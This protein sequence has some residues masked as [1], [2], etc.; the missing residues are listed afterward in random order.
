MK[1]I[2]TD[3][4]SPSRGAD[5]APNDDAPLALLQH[6][7]DTQSILTAVGQLLAARGLKAPWGLPELTP[8]RDFIRTHL[9]RKAKKVAPATL[10]KLTHS[11]KHFQRHCP[12]VNIQ[13]VQGAHVQAWTD[14]LEAEQ[15]SGGTITVMFGHVKQLF[16]KAKGLGFRSGPNPCESVDLPVPDSVVRR[17]PFEPSDVTRLLAFFDGEGLPDWSLATLLGSAAGCRLADAAKMQAESIR[18]EEGVT[19]LSFTPAKTKRAVEIPVFGLLAA[20]LAPFL[21]RTGPICPSL[22][23]QRVETLS[24]LFVA[25]L[26]KAGVDPMPVTLPSGRVVHRLSFHSLRHLMISDLA[27]RGVPESVRMALASHRTQGAHRK[28]V[29]LSGLDLARQMEGYLK[30]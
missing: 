7:T 27:R 22:A 30:A 6:A 11:L 1:R 29:T 25:F 12:G 15:L 4:G 24:H 16:D 14:A 17:L 13:D 2:P 5:K 9:A 10:S 19:I 18:V 26:S 23:S 3:P 28:Y 21:G 8:L 20:R